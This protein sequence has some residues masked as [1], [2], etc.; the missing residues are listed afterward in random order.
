MQTCR[1]GP[2]P[3]LES[4]ERCN[5]PLSAGMASIG[6]CRT[7]QHA[8]GRKVMKVKGAHVSVWNAPFICCVAG[9]FVWGGFQGLRARCFQA[10]AHVNLILCQRHPKSVCERSWKTFGGALCR[11]GT[12]GQMYPERSITGRVEN[13]FPCSKGGRAGKDGNDQSTNMRHLPADS[14]QR[15]L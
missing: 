12:K 6:A 15:T 1:Q 14:I 4:P 3:L 13:E 8:A 2:M 9:W 10:A 5:D 11:H 7:L